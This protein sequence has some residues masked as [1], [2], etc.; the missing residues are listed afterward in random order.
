MKRL[1]A[2][3]YRPPIL[4]NYVGMR[5][6]SWN[7]ASKCTSRNAKDAALNVDT[8]GRAGSLDFGENI[9]EATC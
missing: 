2:K 7:L 4:T 3:R 6:T 8:D 5:A 1:A 9:S